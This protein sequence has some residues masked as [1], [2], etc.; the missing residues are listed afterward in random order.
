MQDVSKLS[1]GAGPSGAPAKRFRLSRYFTVTSLIAFASVA[2]AL[3][4]LQTMELRFF[5]Q[6]QNDQRDLLAGLQSELSRRQERAA[7]DDLLRV[8]ETGHVNLTH[9]LGNVLWSTTFQPLV[10]RTRDFPLERCRSMAVLDAGGK[11]QGSPDT[12]RDCFAELG[13]RITSSPGFAALDAKVHA[14]MRRTTAF[15]VKVYDL[16]GLT[17]YSSE[18]QQIGEDKADNR[19]WIAA[20]AGHPA[21]ELTHRDKFSAFEGVV[22]NRDLISSYIPVV[23]AGS[24]QVVGVFEIYSDVTPFLAQIRRGTTNNSEFNAAVR[25]SV[26]QAAEK[27][28]REVNASSDRLMAVV[29]GLLALLYLALLL[30]VRNAQRIIDQQALEQHRALQREAL[31]HREKMAALA[32]MAANVAHEV[33][34]PLATISALAE[35]IMDQQKKG[36]CAVCQPQ[37]ILS[38]TRR[39]AA[40]TREIAD[41]A[42]ARSESP[43]LVDLNHM[44]KAMCDFMSFDHRFRITKIEFRPADGLPGCLVAPDRLNEI[45]MAMLQGSAE[46]GGGHAPPPARITVYTEARG[47]DLLVRI[48]C[49]PNSAGGGKAVS[50]VIG[51]PRFAEVT[52]LVAG[53]GGRLRQSGST[54]ELAIPQSP[55]ESR[56]DSPITVE[57]PGTAPG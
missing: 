33:G 31:W 28:Q 34:N 16:R 17:V 21:S 39:I 1:H 29:G 26:A 27:N 25:A 12:R 38:R 50:S 54:A 41:F 15:K 40:M 9:L 30:L 2:A 36:N 6:V 45:L 47:N 46:A 19:G 57:P 43:E 51:H 48:A 8:H 37:A 55:P 11:L 56:A 10:S 18:H 32:T 4:V 49:E 24:E 3:Y 23:E 7:I 14:T 35:E 53:I 20:A 44:V 22:E 52:R 5:E 13:R 42:A